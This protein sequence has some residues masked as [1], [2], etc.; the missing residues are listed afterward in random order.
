VDDFNDIL[1]TLEIGQ[2]VTL[3]YRRG[4]AAN[5]VTITLAASPPS[6]G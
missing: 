2:Q 1:H 5:T 3:T 4:V 6:A